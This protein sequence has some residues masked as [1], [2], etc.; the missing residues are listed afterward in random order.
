MSVELWEFQGGEYRK[1]QFRLPQKAWCDF[2]KDEKFYLPAVWA[3]TTFPPQSTCPIPVGEYTMNNFVPD[4]E[5]LPDFLNGRYMINI[6]TDRVGDD[7][8]ISIKCYI[9]I[10]RYPAM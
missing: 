9:E 10:K 2:S 4:P 8:E 5:S 3:K 1:T 6:I 7:S